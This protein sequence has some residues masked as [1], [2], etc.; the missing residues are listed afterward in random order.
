MLKS[1]AQFAGWRK[2]GNGLYLPGMPFGGMGPACCC[3][4]PGVCTYCSDAATVPSQ[5]SVT[6]TGISNNTCSDCGT[7]ND[8][9]VL[10][11]VSDCTWQVD[12]S[13]ICGFTRVSVVLIDT[14]IIVRFTP[15]AYNSWKK[16]ISPPASTNPIDCASIS[17]LTIPWVGAPGDTCTVQY[18]TCKITAIP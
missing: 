18:A 7:L 3:R 4:T 17:D 16:A 8:T 10:D 12:F 15:S 2:H 11:W 14:A 1:L 13:D 5:F 6:F 9:Y